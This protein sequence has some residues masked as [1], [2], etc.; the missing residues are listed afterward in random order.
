MARRRLALELD[1]TTPSQLR[2]ELRD[3]HGDARAFTGWLGLAAALEQM[4]GEGARA[5]APEVPAAPT[6]AQ[7]E[8]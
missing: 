4:L 6:V 1:A 3:E 5:A 2:G 8:P 7:E